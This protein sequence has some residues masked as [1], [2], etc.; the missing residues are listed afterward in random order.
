MD[1]TRL[2]L[3]L[4]GIPGNSKVTLDGAVAGQVLGAVIDPDGPRIVQTVVSPRVARQLGAF[5]PAETT[6]SGVL[7]TE[8]MPVIVRNQRKNRFTIRRL[9]AERGTG[10]VT[11]VLIAESKGFGTTGERVIEA[12]NIA[13]IDGQ[14]LR[15]IETI[16]MI[17]DLPLYRDDSAIAGDVGATLEQILLDP[18]ARRAIHARVE[19]GHVDYSG[20]IDTEE[21]VDS[22]LRSTNVIPGVRAVRS[23]IIVTEQLAD[24]VVAAVDE[25][26]TKGRLGEGAEIEVLSEHQIIYLNGRVATDKISAEVERAALNVPGVRIVVNEL[27]TATPELTIPADPASPQTQNK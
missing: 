1:Q 27:R 4:N 22:L 11:H 23:D 6:S 12:A 13:Q 2:E 15:L 21:W 19:D 7:L 17:E 5:V 18:R 3:R 16:T 20:V 9:W 24:H 25:L 8:K 10:Q 26:R 14:G